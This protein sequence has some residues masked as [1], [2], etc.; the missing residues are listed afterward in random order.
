MPKIVDK[1]EMRA[2]ILDATMA[3]YTDVGF[4]AATISAIA[5]QS[6][7]GKGTIYLYFDSKDTLTIALVE[8]L[9][10]GME[11]VFMPDVSFGSLDDFMRHIRKTM[12]I[13]KDHTRFIRVFFEVF[14]P[15]FASED[16]VESVSSFF[17][18]LGAYYSTQIQILQKRDEVPSH[19]NP[20]VCGR[21]LACMVDGMIL[22]KGL[23]DLSTR[24]HRAM[25]EQA[26][27]LM[28]EGLR[29]RSTA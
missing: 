8:R 23:F 13:P 5:K 1:Q 12:D 10:G 11:G 20:D 6:G 4:H 3:V 24:R 21:A 19:I 25:I 27:S 15:S 18:R 7:L 2:K 14:G 17:E 26:L 29:S 28:A 22:H 9:F 16:F